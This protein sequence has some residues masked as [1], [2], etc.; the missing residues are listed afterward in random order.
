[1]RKQ[2][3][4]GDIKGIRKAQDGIDVGGCRGQAKVSAVGVKVVGGSGAGV[5]SMVFQYHG[6]SSSDKTNVYSLISYLLLI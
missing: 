4:H 6:I 3:L 1:M 5:G 2:G